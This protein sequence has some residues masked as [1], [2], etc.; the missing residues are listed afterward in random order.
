MTLQ[1]SLYNVMINEINHKRM[2]MIE[3]VVLPPTLLIQSFIM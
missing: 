3:T 1:N 2:K